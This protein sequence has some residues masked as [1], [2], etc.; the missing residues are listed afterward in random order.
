MVTEIIKGISLSHKRWLIGKSRE[1]LKICDQGCGAA[2]I[3][4]I[5]AISLAA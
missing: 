5:V 4:G 2:A 3:F 1:V